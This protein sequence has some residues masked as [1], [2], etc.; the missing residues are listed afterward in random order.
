MNK[1]KILREYIQ[2]KGYVTY[3]E[4]SE[5]A[6]SISNDWRSDTWSRG[7]RASKQ[8]EKV[9]K[10]GAVNSPIIGYRYVD[11]K[12]EPKPQEQPFLGLVGG[13]TGQVCNPYKYI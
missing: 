11:I 7:L 12:I 5:Y 4:V 6:Y 1:I 9:Y 13:S 2:A 3:D 10:N 8:I